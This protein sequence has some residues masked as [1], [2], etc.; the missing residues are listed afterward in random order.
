MKLPCAPVGK[1][2][3]ITG[4]V[5]LEYHDADAYRLHTGR[6]WS[7]SSARPHKVQ[8]NRMPGARRRTCRSSR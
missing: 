2:R 8:D 1:M 6:G 7:A 5:E 3:M 4:P